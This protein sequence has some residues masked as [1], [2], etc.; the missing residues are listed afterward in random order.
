[1]AEP[2]ELSQ[3]LLD[4]QMEVLFKIFIK[5]INKQKMIQTG[6]QTRDRKEWN[7]KEKELNPLL[8]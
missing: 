4:K 6:R 7:N 5:E 1:M 2:Y 3:D 8:V